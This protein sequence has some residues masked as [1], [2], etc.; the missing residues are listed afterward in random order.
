MNDGG[1]SLHAEALRRKEVKQR[2]RRRERIKEGFS[3][4]CGLQQNNMT[5][6]ARNAGKE[7]SEDVT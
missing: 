1:K 4:K 5:N 6:A 7:R 3:G 2:N